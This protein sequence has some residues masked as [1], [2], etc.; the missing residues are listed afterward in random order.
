MMTLAPALDQDAPRLLAGSVGQLAAMLHNELCN[1]GYSLMAED[2]LS[3]VV[4]AV[5]KYA[6]W[7]TLDAQRHATG[8]VQVGAGLVLAAHE[9]QIIEPLVRAHC[10][11]I[12]ANRMEASRSLGMEQVGMSVSEA[13]QGLQMQQD[14]L[15]QRAFCAPPF[16]IELDP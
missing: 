12:Q 13:M 9:W 4:Q 7:D 8:D 6:A 5:C 3:C 14:L 15:A 11:L 16:A 2:V 1:S 10:D